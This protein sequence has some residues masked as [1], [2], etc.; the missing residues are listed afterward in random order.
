MT[1]CTT[2]PPFVW[3][4]WDLTKFLQG[5]AS[6]HNPSTSTYQVVRTAVMKHPTQFVQSSIL[7]TKIP[8]EI[9]FII[10]KISYFKYEE[11]E[12]GKNEERFYFGS[13]LKNSRIVNIKV[14]NDSD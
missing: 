5:L 14:P 4:K 10:L 3:L 11:K 2:T 12:E 9:S 7:R 1:G 13:I 8:I 6:I